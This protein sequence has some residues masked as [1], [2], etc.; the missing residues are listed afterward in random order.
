MDDTDG[1]D[2][3]VLDGQHDRGP[4]PGHIVDMPRLCVV[5]A[6]LNHGNN[7]GFSHQQAKEEDVDERKRDREAN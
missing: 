7:D 2:Q 4:D 3:Q 6:V 1:D 5:L